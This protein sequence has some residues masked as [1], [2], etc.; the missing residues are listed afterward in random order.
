MEDAEDE[1]HRQDAEDERQPVYTI[2][3]VRTLSHLVAA[4]GFAL[5]SPPHAVERSLEML[6]LGTAIA[7]IFR[8]L[9]E[10]C[11]LEADSAET[12]GVPLPLLSQMLI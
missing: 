9:Q 10:F 7:K 12:L 5:I 8:K 2:S 11:K 4:P 6:I 1:R 3:S